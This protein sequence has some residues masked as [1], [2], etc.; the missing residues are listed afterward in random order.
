MNTTLANKNFKDEYVKY[1]GSVKPS[2]DL[3]KNTINLA[4]QEQIKLNNSKQYKTTNLKAN[5]INNIFL[6]T[7]F[8]RYGVLACTLVF[9]IFAVKLWNGTNTS[10]VPIATDT[11]TTTS[12]LQ[13]DTT[14][15]T[16]YDDNQEYTVTTVP[17]EYEENPENTQLCGYATD[18]IQS[19]TIG[20][21]TTLQSGDNESTMKW[22]ENILE[23]FT[24][25]TTVP[26]TY[27]D[28]NTAEV[29]YSTDTQ[30][31]YITNT[32]IFSSLI[33][34]SH[35]NTN[36]STSNN[37]TVTT[38][39]TTSTSNSSNTTMSATAIVTNPVTTTTTT[40][41]TNTTFHTTIKVPTESETTI[42][43]TIDGGG[44]STGNNANGSTQSSGAE[45]IE[46]TTLPETTTE[47]YGTTTQEHQVTTNIELV[48]TPPNATENS[49]SSSSVYFGIADV[50]YDVSSILKNG[51]TTQDVIVEVPVIYS[52]STGFCT[53]TF[54]H[55]LYSNTLEAKWSNDFAYVDDS[56]LISDDDFLMN[57][58][59]QKVLIL[60]DDVTNIVGNG[61]IYRLRVVI[62]A[63]SKVGDT[64]TVGY[65]LNNQDIY[66]AQ[67]QF[68][69]AT[70][71]SGTITITGTEDTSNYTP[72]HAIRT[73]FT[74]GNSY[75]DY[76]LTST[77]NSKYGIECLY[78]Y[79]LSN[80]EVV[81]IFNNSQREK[82]YSMYANISSNLTVL[83]DKQ[84][85]LSTD[86]TLDFDGDQTFINEDTDDQNILKN[87]VAFD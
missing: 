23:R 65:N 26:N 2:D 9:A 56:C 34:T 8:K 83:E 84:V 32:P 47:T 77:L 81:M 36:T 67:E 11:V 3:I 54:A 76:N 48:T 78:A 35:T 55:E 21:G 52:S 51:V 68:I 40:T 75:D 57:D 20:S 18:N 50:S 39:T 87:I 63:G 12:I 72:Y 25:T 53:G 69:N 46:S 4:V 60:K 86:D 15:D 49:T 59:N 70:Y 37:T 33:T 29:V 41:F 10:D 64:V 19:S 61:T 80:G 71:K 22:S 7:G 45:I 79:T 28:D 6:N 62:P 73:N 16:T 31:E 5:K 44:G 13:D 74:D 1:M 82:F 38:K 17:T 42:K 66:D 14:Q 27:L 43:T 24:T 85:M 30:S 58:S